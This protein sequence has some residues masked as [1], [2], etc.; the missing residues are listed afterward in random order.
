MKEKDVLKHDL[1]RGW[2][3]CEKSCGR[4]FKKQKC[5][6][7]CD[8]CREGKPPLY[9]EPVVK[10]TLEEREL[11]R[12][13]L[14]E[15]DECVAESET[16]LF[17][18]AEVENDVFDIHEADKLYKK[19]KDIRGIS[20]S[21]RGRS[22]S[23]IVKR[24]KKRVLFSIRKIGYHAARRNAEMTFDILKEMNE[25]QKLDRAIFLINQMKQRKNHERKNIPSVQQPT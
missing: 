3:V 17:K 15:I 20:Y 14:K 5:R 8:S 23:C 2:R 12:I 25:G 16:D 18:M 7:Q 4:M 11:R 19:E 21:I 22:R 13:R 10:T 24:F 9:D 6:T 1:P